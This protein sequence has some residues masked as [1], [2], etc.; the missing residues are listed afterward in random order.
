M[1]ELV[2]IVVE[3]SQNSR[4]HPLTVNGRRL[5][6]PVGEPVPVPESVLPSLDASSV[7]YRIEAEPK[8]E[9]DVLDLLDGNVE[10]IGA[11]I[12]DLTNEELEMLLSAERDGKTRKG[13]VEAIEAA[14]G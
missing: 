2:T 9:T 3:R 13:V 10:E 12:P 14:L 6:L 5:S 4:A 8:A 7:K 1:G 11:A